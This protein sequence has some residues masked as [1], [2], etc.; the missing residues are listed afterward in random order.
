M[1]HKMADRQL[2]QQ[3]REEKRRELLELSQR[4]RRHIAEAAIDALTEGAFSGL[5]SEHEL[6][7]LH[8][9]P[10]RT[11]EY[12]LSRWELVLNNF[13]VARTS[14]EWHWPGKDIDFQSFSTWLWDVLGIPIYEATLS[15]FGWL[16]HVLE[17][18][19][20]TKYA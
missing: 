6:R 8:G 13:W 2:D 17:I 11:T 4:D 9:L 3:R 10:K 18:T 7:W 19:R 1:N 14:E 20:K 5:F 15:Q 16:N 12:F